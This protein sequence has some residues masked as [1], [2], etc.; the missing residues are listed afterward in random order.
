MPPCKNQPF[1]DHFFQTPLFFCYSLDLDPNFNMV[2]QVNK[3]LTAINI[4]NATLALAK[5]QTPGSRLYIKEGPLRHRGIEI[6]ANKVNTGCKHSRSPSS[7]T[8]DI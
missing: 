6:G 1:Q 8:D 2:W 5:C 3:Q 7:D 4:I